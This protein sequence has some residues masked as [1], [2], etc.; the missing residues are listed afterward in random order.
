MAVNVLS[1][2]IIAYKLVTV[3]KITNATYSAPKFDSGGL[4]STLHTP[5]HKDF[6]EKYFQGFKKEDKVG[7]D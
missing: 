7:L 6:R 2:L 5:A 4:D 1:L 3:R